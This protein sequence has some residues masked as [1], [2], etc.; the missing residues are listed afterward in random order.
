M[1][2]VPPSDPSDGVSTEI[3][4][5]GSD[6]TSGSPL[7]QASGDSATGDMLQNKTSE[8]G[9]LTGQG[10][11]SSDLSPTRQSVSEE[12]SS[13]GDKRESTGVA[14]PSGE[15]SLGA[16]PVH[17][18]QPKSDELL[19][20]S[21]ELQSDQRPLTSLHGSPN[22]GRQID[23]EN[24]ST[25]KTSHPNK[26]SP[27]GE[28]GKAGEQ[29]NGLFSQ[30]QQGTQDRSLPSSTSFSENARDGTFSI[31]HNNHNHN[32]CETTTLYNAH[33]LTIGVQTRARDIGT[34]DGNSS[35]L[36]YDLGGITIKT[37]ITIGLSILGFILLLIFL[38]KFTAFGR[39]FSKKKKN[40]RQIIQEELHRIMY[41]P[42]SL[43]E[44][45]IYMS[46]GNSEYSQYDSQY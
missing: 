9:H 3:S 20:S 34:E 27:E 23:V 41:S 24:S 30:S 18:E 29:R 4:A 33:F 10:Q 43:E 7:V 26:E 32:Y 15:V 39:I 44:Q 12:Q 6:Q 19:K 38:I 22:E 8:E 31:V 14:S 25:L 5:N 16:Q 11:S 40:N 1:V 42:S 21:V 46:Y 35:I 37:Y 13:P 36:D 17:G 2:P 28:A 45:N